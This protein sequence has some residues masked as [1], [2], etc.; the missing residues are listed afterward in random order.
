MR[1]KVVRAHDERR[2]AGIPATGWP[3]FGHQ[4]ACGCQPKQPRCSSP[5]HDRWVIQKEEAKLIRDAVRRILA[6][7]NLATICREWDES[8]VPT[9]LRG[10]WRLT[11]LRRV[12]TAPRLAGILVHNGIEIGTSDA[13]EPV[14]DE[15]KYRRL[16]EILALKRQAKPRRGQQLLTGVLVCGV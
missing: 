8:N 6:G 10:Q 9:R 15:A 5:R 16:C 13:I 2:R 1:E 3:G 7:T 4:R 14:L 12:L 11:T